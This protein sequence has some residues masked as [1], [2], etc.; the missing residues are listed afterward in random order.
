VSSGGC[1]L[2]RDDVSGAVW[3]EERWVPDCS[4]AVYGYV[5][6]VVHLVQLSLP[7]N[8][9]VCIH[10]MCCSRDCGSP[11]ALGS[12]SGRATEACST[13]P[14]PEYRL[15]SRTQSRLYT[16]TSVYRISFPCSTPS[17]SSIRFSRRRHERSPKYDLYRLS[18]CFSPFNFH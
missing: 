1:G 14:Y 11:R 6:T 8:P 13:K 4:C 7:F 12:A 16:V 15:I 17:I 10:R 18:L 9:C 5:T 3:Y 2:C